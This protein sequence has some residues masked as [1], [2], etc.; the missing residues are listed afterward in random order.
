M[1]LLFS[2]WPWL[3][4]VALIAVNVAVTLH[5]ALNKRH[6]QAA[7]AWIGMIWAVPV[8]S[9]VLYYVFGINRIERRARRIRGKPR[10]KK[11]PA[12]APGLPSSSS[13]AIPLE[14]AHLT[15]L[16]ILGGTVTENSLHAGNAIQPL[17]DGDEAYPAMLQAID[18]AAQSIALSMYIFSNDAT[19]MLFVE[20]LG[21]AVARGVEVRVLVDDIGAHLTWRSI[22]APLRLAKVPAARFL[23]T[24]IPH[25]FSYANLRSHRKMLIVDGRIGFTG[26]M[27]IS[28]SY[29]P[30]RKPA[31]PIH[32][33]QFRVEG[34]VI[35]DMMKVFVADW[36]FA[37]GERLHGQSW[38]PRLDARGPALA[39]A[40]STGPD[41]DLNRLR[42]IFLGALSNAR[43]RVTIVTPY[44]LP[45]ASLIS[46]LNI[47]ALRGVQVDIVLP[48]DSDLRLVCW[49]STAQ[50]PQVLEY[51]CRIWHMPAPFRH[52]KL[53]IVDGVWVNL[54]SANWD[55]RSLR[56]N[57]EFNIECYDPALAARLQADIDV[58]ITQAESITLAKITE[59]P[60]WVR[61]RDGLAWLLTP[62]L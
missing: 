10:R 28:D 54:G 7:V 61:V 49:A 41:E 53:M 1:E 16:A 48:R 31:C 12:G 8:L 45:D 23:P 38:F 20:A 32:D 21:R 30:S 6:P 51:G 42:L 57:F 60:F 40:I 36:A 18:Q 62:Y 3:L 27:N 39:R 4:S 50:L 58:G 44:F 33:L 26:G 37:A 52:V 9:L 43:T 17:R 25:F 19:G 55:E 59:R 14:A 22:I 35:A 2:L 34:P 5:A 29:W 15:P 13:F 24:L 47:A 11:T 56:L 46:A